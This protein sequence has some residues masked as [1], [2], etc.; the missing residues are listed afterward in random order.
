MDHGE[1]DA[2]LWT[3]EQTLSWIL[4]RSRKVAGLNSSGALAAAL[5]AIAHEIEFD[6][7]DQVAS[8][9]CL[10]ECLDQ[11]PGARKLYRRISQRLLYALKKGREPIPTWGTKED[12]DGWPCIDRMYWLDHVIE[13][14]HDG[15]LRD[16]RT[17]GCYTPGYG[18]YKRIRVDRDA[19]LKEWEE[20]PLQRQQ[21]FRR[22]SAREARARRLI[23]EIMRQSPEV[24]TMSKEDVYIEIKRQVPGLGSRPFDR[25]WHDAIKDAEAQ[26]W[27]RPGPRPRQ[28]KSLQ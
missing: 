20:P 19:V 2:P 13:P 14:D 7:A 17:D 12:G 27:S 15:C 6:P 5:S 11:D 3:F 1:F 4:T 21:S 25:A 26:A 28:K 24:P 18:N 22:T 16:S 9:M 23:C 8:P 10:R